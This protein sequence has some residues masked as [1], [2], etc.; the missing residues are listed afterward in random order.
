MKSWGVNNTEPIRDSVLDII[1]V[2]TGSVHV[3][4]YNQDAKFGFV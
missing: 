4:E 3:T 1:N 2:V